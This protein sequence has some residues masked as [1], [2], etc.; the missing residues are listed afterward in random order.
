MIADKPAG[1]LQDN[2]GRRQNKFNWHNRIRL[3][4]K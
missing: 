2:R 1:D 4:N 3:N